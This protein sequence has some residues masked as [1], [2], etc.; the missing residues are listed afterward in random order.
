MPE[1]L[2][3]L[4]R[5]VAEARQDGRRISVIGAGHSPNACAMSPDIMVSLDHC[6]RIIH[7]DADAQQV[8]VRG[9]GGYALGLSDGTPRTIVT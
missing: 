9:V 4:Q 8:T 6:N 5:I 1:D 3:A 2:P 7:V